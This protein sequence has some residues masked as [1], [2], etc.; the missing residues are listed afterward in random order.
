MVSDTLLYSMVGSHMPIYEAQFSAP[1]QA[2]G[3]TR[4][5]NSDF[6]VFSTGRR[7]I[8]SLHTVLTLRPRHDLFQLVYQF[9]RGII[10]L[11]WKVVDEVELDFTFQEGSNVPECIWAVVSK[12]ELRGIRD[13]RW[14]LSF[15]RTTDHPSLPPSLTVMSEFADVTE[16][17]FKQHGPFS[18]SSVLSS[19]ELLPYFRSLS[20]TDQPRTRPLAPLPASQR[21][22][23]LTLSLALPR[24]AAASTTLPIVDAA[25]KLVDIV[26][27]TGG[28]GVGKGPGGKPG[29]GL[30]PSLK[31]ETRTKLRVTREKLGKELK[32]EA[33]KEQREEAEEKKVAAKKKAEEERLSK[34]SA[35]EQKKQLERDRK[36]MLRKTQGKVAKAR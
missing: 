20:L 34:L 21:T 30:N 15:T 5:G 16:N 14:D 12:D 26:T 23:H 33:V 17:M 7:A 10:E 31:P 13:R 9:I 32:E 22:K 19:P 11:D 4:D 1:V 3:L 6:F 29:V 25:F 24:S 36:R 27:G 2:G 35:A 28:W 8:S 18:L